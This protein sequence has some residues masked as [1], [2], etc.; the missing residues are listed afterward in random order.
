MENNNPIPIKPVDTGTKSKAVETLTGDIIKVIETNKE[1][2]VKKIIHEQEDKDE[3]S[4]KTSPASSKNKIFTVLGLFLIILAILAVVYVLFNKDKST[5]E[6]SPQFAPIIFNEEVKLLEIDKLNK[7][8]ISNMLFGETENLKTKIAG[9]K[10]LYLTQNKAPVGFHDF[11]HAID[12]NL[13]LEDASLINQNFLIGVVD[14]DKSQTPPLSGS[15]FILFNVRSF[16]DI[17][18]V[19][20]SWEKKMFLDL[21]GIFGIDLSPETK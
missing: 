7:E 2:I 14:D 13:V 6:I 17:F 10:G 15:P 3:E 21:H 1:G 12:T 19:M 11:M 20:N 16:S 8:Q 18:P 5:V 4:N 9:V